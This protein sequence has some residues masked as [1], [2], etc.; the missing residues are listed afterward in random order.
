MK[1]AVG[2][3]WVGGR[4]GGGGVIEGRGKV[5]AKGGAADREVHG[6]ARS[7]GRPGG[8]VGGD[9]AEGGGADVEAEGSEDLEERPEDGGVWGAG[10]DDDRLLLAT[11]R[12]AL[13]LPPAIEDVSVDKVAAVGGGGREAEGEDAVVNGGGGGGAVGGVGVEVVVGHGVGE[14]GEGDEE[15]LMVREGVRGEALLHQ[16]P[17]L[18]VEADDTEGHHPSP[19]R[20][21]VRARPRPRGVAPQR[22]RR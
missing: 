6:G 22:H 9:Q 8:D 7:G 3:G 15:E 13:V 12:E 10:E 16:L 17:L 20:L 1:E 21:R 11:A 18:Q 14:G 5:H 19:Q 2:D 4:E